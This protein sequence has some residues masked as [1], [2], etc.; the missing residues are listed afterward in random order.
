MKIHYLK[1]IDSTQS[2]LKKLILKSKIFESLAVVADIQTD[3]VGSRDNTWLGL[4]GNLFLSFAIPLQ[5]LPNDLK[6]ESSSLYFSQI[7]K[8]TLE[9]CESKVWLK[10]PNDFYIEDKKIGG[11]IT[12]I[13]KGQLVCGVGLNL[14]SSPKSFSHLDVKISRDTLLEIYTKNIEKK[15]SWKQ[16]FS[17]YKLNFYLNQKY[18]AHNNN[19]RISLENAELQDDGSII[20]NGERIYSLR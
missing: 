6:L 9:E 10:W 12:N 1:S 20:V 7:L 2:Y 16:I 17:K 14:I 18:Y 19:L 13:V 8:D 3:G 5:D 15:L 11:M 4:D